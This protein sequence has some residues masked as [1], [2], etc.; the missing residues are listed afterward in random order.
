M[1]IRAGE[2]VTISYLPPMKGN[3]TRR[4]TIRSVSQSEAMC[5]KNTLIAEICGILSARVRGVWT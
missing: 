2:E 3:I 4:R 1:D 5:D